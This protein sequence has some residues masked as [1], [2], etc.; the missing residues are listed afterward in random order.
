MIDRCN[1]DQYVERFFA[2][3]TTAAEEEAIYRFFAA[4]KTTNK[5]WHGM[6]AG[7]NTTHLRYYL[8]NKNAAKRPSFGVRWQPLQ[9]L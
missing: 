7:C 1:I 8:S 5:C 9:P 6:P 2:G 4:G 3:D